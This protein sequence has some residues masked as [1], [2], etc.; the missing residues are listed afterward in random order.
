MVTNNVARVP[1]DPQTG[2]V[3]GS[4]ESLTSGPRDFQSIDVSPGGDELVLQTSFR[5]QE[6]L[7][8]M[9]ADGS[10]LRNLT[11]DRSRDRSPQWSADGRQVL[12]YGDRSGD[13]ELWS[14]DR[15]GGG[16]SQLTKS[17]GQRYYPVPSPDGSR[18]A[19]A[20]IN[21]W[22]LFTHDA[23]DLTKPFEQLAPLPDDLRNGVMGI[24]DWSPDGES[25]IGVAGGRT[26]TYSFRSRTYRNLGP[27]IAA[28]WLPDSRRLIGAA[29]GRIVVADATGS[30]VT[31]REVLAI[32]GEALN[33]PRLS[34]DGKMLYFLRGSSSGD[35]WTVRF[36]ASQP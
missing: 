27:A 28:Q 33:V 21:A 3:S 35:I 24:L 19:A 12:F 36:S 6:D 32:P 22:A 20:D 9:S 26:W 2:T 16:L 18:I 15:D 1:F 11:N 4:V 8:L 17:G 34:R 5:T 13:Y 25:L 29:Q 14:I 7:Y 31:P 23:R 30:F 10:G